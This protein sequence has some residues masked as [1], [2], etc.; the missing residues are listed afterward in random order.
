MNFTKWFPVTS[1]PM[2]ER[3]SNLLE[4]FTIYS[5]NKEDCFL[6]YGYA[7]LSTGAKQTYKALSSL[8]A[9]N[10]TSDSLTIAL[11]YLAILLNTSESTQSNRISEL[12]KHQLITKSKNINN[13]N[14]YKVHPPIVDNTFVTTLVNLMHRKQLGTLIRNYY[15]N[16]SMKDKIEFLRQIKMRS[17][18]GHYHH[19]LTGF[20]SETINPSTSE[21]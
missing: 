13:I 2:L 3:V 17:K 8:N 10:T 1:K 15:T 16:S 6:E 14:Q 20:H 9:L 11:D 18:R 12:V 4:E 21:S 19:K 5:A 7:T